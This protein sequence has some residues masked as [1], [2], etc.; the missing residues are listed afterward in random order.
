MPHSV[1][2]IPPSQEPAPNRIRWTR[3]QCDAIRDA[4]ILVGRYEL[5]DGEIISKMGQNPPH[6]VAVVLLAA[7]L[8]RVFGALCVR[9]QATVD[10]GDADPQHNEPEPDVA[11]TREPA[12]AYAD[13]HPNPA[14]LV[15]VAEVSDT[16]LRFDRGVKALLYA[17]AG[18]SEY[19][20]LDLGGRQLFQ[21][22]RP[23]SEGYAEITVYSADETVAT[24][25][26][27]DSPARVADL[28]PPSQA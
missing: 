2:P 17:R 21:H 11:V 4:G 3:A 5:V 6:S 16:T 20:V 27:P 28:L 7:Y 19:W 1:K 15:L 8:S 13:R 12:T 14:D 24:L 23:G 9:S 26:R 18:V 22:R 10:V 25:A